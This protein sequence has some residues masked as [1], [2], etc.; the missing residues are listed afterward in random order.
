MYREPL[1]EVP[2]CAEWWFHGAQL[3]FIPMNWSQYRCS[4]LIMASALWAHTLYFLVLTPGLSGW[5]NWLS[6]TAELLLGCP[7]EFYVLS[8]ALSHHVSLPQ[9]HRF[10]IT[11]SATA[12][13]PGRPHDKAF[14]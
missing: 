14:I 6:V 7:G 11:P 12:V 2:G 10:G 5:T 8:G 13:L 4:R 9:L 1:S 3:V